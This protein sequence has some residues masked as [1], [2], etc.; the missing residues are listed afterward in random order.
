MDK[1]K[2]PEKNG[3]LLIISTA[4]FSV[5]Y[6][7]SIFL[8]GMNVS[9]AILNIALWVCICFGQNWARICKMVLAVLIV[10]VYIVSGCQI[11]ISYSESAEIPDINIKDTLI[12][13]YDILRSSAEIFILYRYAGKAENKSQLQK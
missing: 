2:I 5:L 7:V 4:V 10:S 1:F 8:T 6:F 12:I 11:L 13:I 3:R 9:M